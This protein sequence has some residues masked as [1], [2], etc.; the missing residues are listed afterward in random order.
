MC[1]C[2]LLQTAV[3]IVNFKVISKNKTNNILDVFLLY[4][5]HFLNS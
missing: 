1:G 2:E 4:D 5:D 3:N